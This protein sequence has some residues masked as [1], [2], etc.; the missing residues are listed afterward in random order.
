MSELRMKSA[1]LH[2]WSITLST[3][4]YILPISLD[5]VQRSAGKRPI[6]KSYRDRVQKTFD[7]HQ[8]Y[9]LKFSVL[10][11]SL[12][13]PISIHLIFLHYLLSKWHPQ[14]SKQTRKKS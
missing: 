12:N 4:L 10:S 13:P 1:A 3:L 5:G 9:F 2:F 6:V 8:F 11:L 7:I 14:Q